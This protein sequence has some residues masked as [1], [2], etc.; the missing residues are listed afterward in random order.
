MQ[1]WEDLR[2]LA[3]KVCNQR[4]RKGTVHVADALK[5]QDD[6][7]V[8]MHKRLYPGKPKSSRLF[9]VRQKIPEL[10]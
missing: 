3:H 2:A 8:G 4:V 6:L 7:V 5:I 1:F 10:G 9:A